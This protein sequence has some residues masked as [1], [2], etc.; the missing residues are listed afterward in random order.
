[1][2]HRIGVVD[3]TSRFY[4]RYCGEAVSSGGEQHK[5][6]R[7][8]QPRLLHG[9]HTDDLNSVQALFSGCV[10]TRVTV[11]R[12]AW[13]VRHL[14]SCRSSSPGQVRYQAGEAE[15]LVDE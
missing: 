6:D 5:R 7:A 4:T 3:P 8:V 2:T 14:P 1:M 9:L 11:I 15:N 13:P 12:V 10:K